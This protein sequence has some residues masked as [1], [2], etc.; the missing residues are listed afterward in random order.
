MLKKLLLTMLLKIA[1]IEAAEI[2]FYQTMLLLTVVDTKDGSRH[3]A[4]AP[5]S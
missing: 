4:D 3:I 5:C 1:I 2:E